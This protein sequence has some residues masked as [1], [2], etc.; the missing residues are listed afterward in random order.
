MA[1]GGSSSGSATAVAAGAVS[2]A[3]GTDTAGSGR[4]PAGLQGLVGVKPSVGIISTQGAQHLLTLR[5]GRHTAQVRRCTAKGCSGSAAAAPC[6][7]RVEPT[8]A[9]HFVRSHAY[10]MTTL[11]LSSACCASFAA[12]VRC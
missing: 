8:A 5:H 2:F 9:H 10:Y 11:W 4:V 7:L 12:G 1:A 6:S 3:I